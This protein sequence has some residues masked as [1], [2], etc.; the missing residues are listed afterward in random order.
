MF[1]AVRSWA[2]KLASK[3]LPTL[4]RRIYT[5]EKMLGLIEVTISSE[6][7]GLVV[8][9]AELPDARA[10]LEITNLSPFTLKL[11]GIEAI[12]YWVGRAAEFRSM[13]RMEIKAHTKERIFIETSINELQSRHISKNNELDKPRLYVS[14]YLESSLRSINKQRDI[15]TSNFRLLNCH[16][17]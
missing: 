14:L 6:N 12:L 2:L 8:N 11:V 3:L 9:C 13:Q 10:W 5:Y 17:A 1:E 4:F 7:D 15:Q 16:G